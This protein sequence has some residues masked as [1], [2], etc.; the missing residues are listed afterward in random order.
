MTEVEQLAQEYAGPKGRCVAGNF[1]LTKRH[2]F[3]H[4]LKSEAF[5]AGFL[6][7]RNMIVGRMNACAGE[8]IENGDKATDLVTIAANLAFFGERE[9]NAPTG[10]GV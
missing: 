8:L 10:K 3:E 7:C 2:H 6:K 5:A 4:N 1:E 9:V